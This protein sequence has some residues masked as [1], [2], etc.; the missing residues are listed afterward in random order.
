VAAARFRAPRGA[1]HDRPDE[2]LQTVVRLEKLLA[3]TT[4]SAEV[5]ARLEALLRAWSD[6]APATADVADDGDGDGD[7]L[8][9]EELFARLDREY[10]RA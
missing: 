7:E 4:P 2:A 5:T 1:A 3:D 9:D 8:S 10:G 6:Q